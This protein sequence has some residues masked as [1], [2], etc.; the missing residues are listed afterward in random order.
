MKKILFIRHANSPI[1]NYK[2]I[3]HDRPLSNQGISE[4]EM[5]SGRLLKKQ[6][7]PEKFISSSAIRAH[8]TAEI[9][10]NKLNKDLDIQLEEKIYHNG[11]E[12]IKD[13]ISDTSNDID[14]IV[15]FGHN[16][17][18]EKI[19]SDI[20]NLSYEK[21]PTCAAALCS[22]DINEW[23]NFSIKSSKLEYYDYP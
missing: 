11:R 14:F 16:P 15:I 10:K 6:I 1:G 5:M 3:D 23:K 7:I 19:Y 4:A 12:G 18:L 2:L 13:V 21:F 22:L 17:T 9:M 20:A 8:S